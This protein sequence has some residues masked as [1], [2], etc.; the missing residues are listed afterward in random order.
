MKHLIR[1]TSLFVLFIS[2]CRVVA[3]DTTGY[4]P[5]TGSGKNIIPYLL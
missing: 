2:F 5:L 1:Y 4:T 3:Y